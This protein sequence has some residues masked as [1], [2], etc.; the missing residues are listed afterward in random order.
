VEAALRQ[1]CD[2]LRRKVSKLECKLHACGLRL[3]S[4]GD[5]VEAVDSSGMEVDINVIQTRIESL[6]ANV[7]E[8][9]RISVLGKVAGLSTGDTCL[10]VSFFSDGLKLADNAFV[11][12]QLRP[13]QEIIKD[14]LDC[15]LPRKLQ[16]EYPKG[17]CLQ[18]VNRTGSTFAAWLRD[19][20]SDDKDLVEGGDRLR[21]SAGRAVHKDSRSPGDRFLAK[22]PEHVVKEGQVVN[23]RGA[24]AKR[25][26][27]VGGPGLSCRNGDV[28]TSAG[29]KGNE[30]C[31]LDSN[32]ELSAPSAKLQ[33]KFEGG[34]RLLLQMEPHATIGLL[35]EVLERWRAEH[36][37][38]RMSA[39]GRTYSLRT[40]FPPKEYTE[41][42]M[43]LEDAGLMPTATLFVSCEGASSSES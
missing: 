13:A 7:D 42:E 37:L 10:P 12:Y 26:S 39:K 18:V 6:N 24:V 15:K 16:E 20:A 23:I 11:P 9:S 31:V 14:I 3:A 29:Y 34:Q 19:S 43:T 35:W 36:G 8:G 21:P 2:D 33:V 41:L 5:K 30:V 4:P 17:V 22:L 27:G 32:R 28:V 25:L 40:A 1:E 38:V